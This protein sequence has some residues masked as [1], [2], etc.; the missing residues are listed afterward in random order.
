M[1]Q[2][3]RE[4]LIPG[5]L[6]YIENL[7]HDVSY[8]L[9]KNTNLS[10]MVGIFKKLDLVSSDIVMPWNAAIFDWFDISQM[11]YIKEES[12]ANKHTIREVELG[13]MW[14]FYE[15]KKFKIQQDMETRAVNLCLQKII[16]D[17]YFICM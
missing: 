15:V 14:R 2:V 1:Q 10:I 11:K 6:Y 12:E 16:G 3:I 9:I 13:Y 8:N 7:T 17:P 5:K 4:K